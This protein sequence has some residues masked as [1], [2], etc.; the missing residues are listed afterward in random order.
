VILPPP[1]TSQ[2]THESVRVSNGYAASFSNVAGASRESS[3]FL[4]RIVGVMFMRVNSKCAPQLRPPLALNSRRDGP[5]R[6]V[7]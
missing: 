3:I 5:D 1:A 4:R 2:Q 6:E 7:K